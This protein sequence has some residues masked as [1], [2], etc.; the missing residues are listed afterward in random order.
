VEELRMTNGLVTVDVDAHTGTFAIDGHAGLGRLVDDGDAGD[1]YNYNPPDHDIVVEGAEHLAVHVVDEG[2]LR[3]RIRIDATYR[4]PQRVDDRTLARVGEEIVE[5]STTIELR[6][7]ERFVRVSTAVDNRCEDHRL[8]AW[9]PLLVPATVSRAEC[10]FDIVTRGLTADSGPTEVGLPTFPSRRFVQAGGLTIAH[11]GLLEYELLDIAGRGATALALTL[12]RAN[13]YLSRGPMSHR[14]M[15][16]GPVI[17]LRG[18]QVQGR[19]TLQYAVALGDVDPYALADHAFT[20]L[21][22]AYGAGLGSLPARHQALRVEGMPVSSVRRRR[23]GLEVRAF[24]PGS[25]EATLRIAARRGHVVDL[26]GNV[27]AV[28]DESVVVGPHGIVTIALD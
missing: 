2:P 4:W 18:S 3:A 27:R 24:N 25:G 10:A 23:G 11:E 28:F 19:H 14:P 22:V 6:A 15:P 26:R 21:R 5:V 12:L 1:T 8:R 9:F 17:E 13:R 16:A 20:A 7:G